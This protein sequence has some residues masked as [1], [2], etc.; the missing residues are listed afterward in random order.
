MRSRSVQKYR[1][2]PIRLNKKSSNSIYKNS[3]SAMR[4]RS[5]IKSRLDS[6]PTNQ[7]SILKLQKSDINIRN[8]LNNSVFNRLYSKPEKKVLFNNSKSQSNSKPEANRFLKKLRKDFESK[9]KII[10]F[11]SNYD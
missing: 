6:S 1:K 5:T 7:K 8:K 4:A 2:R 9:K 3:I 11:F 10:E